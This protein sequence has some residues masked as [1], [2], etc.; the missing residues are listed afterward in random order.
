MWPRLANVAVGIWLM[1]APAVLA[2]GDKA[3]INDRIVGP[4][5]ITFA[6]TAIWE[7]TRAVRWVNVAQGVWMLIV[8]WIL[9]YGSSTLIVNSMVAGVLLITFGL[10]RGPVEQQF[11]GGWPATWHP[12][13]ES[14]KSS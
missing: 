4:V 13:Q 6:T 1:A 8:P 3:A 2:Y 14:K 9:M 11:G 5:A 10:V 12:R 7:S